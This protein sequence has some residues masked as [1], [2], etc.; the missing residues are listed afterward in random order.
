MVQRCRSSALLAHGLRKAGAAIT[1]E[2]GAT[3]HQLMAI[4]G[5]RTIKEAQR[6]ARAARQKVLAGSGM[7]LLR[8]SRKGT[9]VSDPK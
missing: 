2:N 9:K 4:Y 6:Y 3:D 8:R 5:W 7:H 1:V